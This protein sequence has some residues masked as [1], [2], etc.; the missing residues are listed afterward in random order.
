MGWYTDTRNHLH[1]LMK[2]WTSRNDVKPLTRR[3]RWVS[4]L[5]LWSGSRNRV[6]RKLKPWDGMGE[7]GKAQRLPARIWYH[8]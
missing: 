7:S 8:M 3:A 4:D 6:I 5:S 2:Q 1:P